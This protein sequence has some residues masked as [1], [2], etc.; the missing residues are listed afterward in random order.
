MYKR[1]VSVRNEPRTRTGGSTGNARTAVVALLFFRAA[2]APVC[3]DPPPSVIWSSQ[4]HASD[5]PE[6][7]LLSAGE[8]PDGE[9]R[10]FPKNNVSSLPRRILRILQWST[11]KYNPKNYLNFVVLPLCMCLQYVRRAEE[12]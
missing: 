11:S 4:Q 1:Q 7:A 9:L 10:T 3:V 8:V 2:R 5:K 12:P 6:G